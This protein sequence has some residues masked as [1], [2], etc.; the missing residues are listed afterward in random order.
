MTDILDKIDH[1][2]RFVYWLVKYHPSSNLIFDN[3]AWLMYWLYAEEE[4]ND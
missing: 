4:I 3:M 1:Y 2:K